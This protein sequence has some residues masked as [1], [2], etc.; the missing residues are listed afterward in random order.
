MLT[1]KASTQ[2]KKDAKK[3]IKAGRPADKLTKVIQLLEREDSLP[4]KNHDHA[5][6]GNYKDCR[7]CHIE[8]DWL[9]IYIVEGKVLRLVRTGSH[10][11]LF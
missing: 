6:T 10:S 1:V 2:F 7:E 3:A 4:E 11:N 5:L 9:L 8:P